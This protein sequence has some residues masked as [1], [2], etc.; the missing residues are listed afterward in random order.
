M[1]GR[2]VLKKG[3][4]WTTGDGSSI[5]V[6]KDPWL[7]TD[8]PRLP[9]GPPSEENRNLTVFHGKNK[10]YWKYQGRFQ[11][12]MLQGRIMSFQAKRSK[13]RSNPVSRQFL[14][15]RSM[16][17]IRGL[18]NHQ[19]QRS[20]WIWKSRRVK[21]CL[22]VESRQTIQP[23]RSYARGVKTCPDRPDSPT[24]VLEPPSTTGH[25]ARVWAVPPV[26][27]LFTWSRNS[28]QHLT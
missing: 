18:P 24:T 9:I 10:R 19:I 4:G 21:I 6:W 27:H 23:L 12:F 26:T 28:S 1:A 11:V 16:A 2:E 17:S 8:L 25:E 14:Y 22:E 7:S 15:F 5:S 13:S 3:L 20:R